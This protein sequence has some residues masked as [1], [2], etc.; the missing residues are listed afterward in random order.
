[1]LHFLTK[2]ILFFSLILVIGQTDTLQ[3]AETQLN[4]SKQ[5]APLFRK[6]CESCHNVDDPEGKF[7]IDSYSSL[8]KGGKHGPALL[9][10]DSKSSRLI[11]MVKGEAKPVMPPE[12]S[13]EKLNPEEIALLVE[14][15]DQGAKGPSGKEPARMK[16]NGP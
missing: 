13:G 11:R 16:I 12:D 8:L 5:I 1:M 2:S 3:A 15:I 4:Y 14:W 6:Y 10:G 7:A 9:P